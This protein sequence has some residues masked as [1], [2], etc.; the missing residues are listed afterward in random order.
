MDEG[1][2]FSVTSCC[3]SLVAGIAEE[4]EHSLSLSFAREEEKVIFI[5]R[6][7]GFRKPRSFVLCSSFLCLR[8]GASFDVVRNSIEEEEASAACRWCMTSFSLF[9]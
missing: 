3:C 6:S 7:S 8:S 2:Y 4:S 1:D 5:C 9:L